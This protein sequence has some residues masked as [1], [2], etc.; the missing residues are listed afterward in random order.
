LAVIPEVLTVKRGD[1]V[2]WTD[3]DTLPY[4]ITSDDGLFISPVLAW[5]SS[6]SYT[7]KTVGT[8]HYHV[9]EDMNGLVGEV[10]VL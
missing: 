2:T 7:F 1:T 8:Y 6:W 3:Y 4:T 9:S 10:I 5:G